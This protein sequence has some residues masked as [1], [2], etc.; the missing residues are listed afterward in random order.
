MIRAGTSES[1][2]F[3]FLWARQRLRCGRGPPQSKR[4]TVGQGSCGRRNRGGSGWWGG[5]GGEG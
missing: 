1:C 3:R 2:T 4:V 5:R